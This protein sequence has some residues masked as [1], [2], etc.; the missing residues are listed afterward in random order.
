MVAIHSTTLPA[1]L[2][3]GA[4]MITYQREAFADIEVEF[5][6]LAEAHYLEIAHYQDIP[7][8]PDWPWY[9]SCPGLRT[10]TVRDGVRLIGYGIFFIGLNKHYQTSMQATQDVLFLLPEYRGRTVGPHLIR[11]CE[12]Q[13]R[14]EGAQ[15]IYQ[16]VKLAHDWG[17][18]L[19]ATGYEEVETIYAKRLD[20]G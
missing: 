2:G 14:A 5:K 20:K 18:L 11:Y 7:L 8:V 17:R 9:R 3:M 16:H 12:E 15:A 6:P 10:F 1:S 19:L 4:G 13:L